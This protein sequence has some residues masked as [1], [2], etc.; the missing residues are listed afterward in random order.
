LIDMNSKEPS[1]KPLCT[2]EGRVVRGAGR[3][4]KFGMP[5]A[6]LALAPGTKL[7]QLGVYAALVF[8]DGIWYE[9]VTNVGFQPSVGGLKQITVETHILGLNRD[10]YGQE[11]RL[12]L[13]YFLRDTK[14]F[15]SLRE[16]KIQIDQDSQ[17]VVEL[18]ADIFLIRRSGWM[19]F[20][21]NGTCST[22]QEDK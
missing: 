7:P 16:V 11:I 10:I 9:G 15:N 18:L 1:I 20:S 6:N 17:R 12:E 5:T 13:Y 22:E 21:A 3:G 4:K 2:M 14:S 8:C 19:K